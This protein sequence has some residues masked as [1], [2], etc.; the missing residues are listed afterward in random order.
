[1]EIGRALE[2]LERRKAKERQQSQADR[3]K[4]GG[5]GNKKNPSSKS[6]E[7]LPK[8]QPPADHDVGRTDEKVAAKVGM[9][10]DA[11]RKAKAVVE[12]DDADPE[13]NGDLPGLALAST[14]PLPFRRASRA[15]AP[16]ASA[17]FQ[18][19][20]WLQ[21]SLRIFFSCRKHFQVFDWYYVTSPSRTAAERNSMWPQSMQIKG[22]KSIGARVVFSGSSPSQPELNRVPLHRKQLG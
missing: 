18:S 15:L 16:L 17:P 21:G 10:R 20:S 22:I 1:V 8:A 7:G 3:G 9:G 19:L 13:T 6:D 14:R 4:E 5:R 11:Y 12:A 2:D